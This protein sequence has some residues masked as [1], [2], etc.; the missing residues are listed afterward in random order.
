MKTICEG[1]GKRR[2]AGG[3]RYCRACILE[4]LSNPTPARV[5]PASMPYPPIRKTGR[6]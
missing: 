2:A 1:C 6:R 3:H 5:Q 4:L